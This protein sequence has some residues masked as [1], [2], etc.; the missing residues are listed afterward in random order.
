MWQRLTG[1]LFRVNAVCEVFHTVCC[2]SPQSFLF[3]D[4]FGVWSNFKVTE[5]LK[6]L[7][8]Q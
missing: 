4:H 5:A 6:K 3:A 2:F 1:F 8:G 7:I